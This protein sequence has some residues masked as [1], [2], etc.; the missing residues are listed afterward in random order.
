MRRL[1]HLGSWFLDLR[2]DQLEWSDETYRIFQIDKAERQ[3]F[4]NFVVAVHPD[5]RERVTAAWR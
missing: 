4:E 3:S 5:D 2:T 1:L